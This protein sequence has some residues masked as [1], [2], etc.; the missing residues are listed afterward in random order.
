MV[1]KVPQEA[2]TELLNIVAAHPNG[3]TAADIEKALIEQVPRRTLQYRLQQLVSS[4]QLKST[5]DR[6][7]VKYL[8]ISKDTPDA[9]AITSGDDY[10][11]VI[12]LSAEGKSFVRMSRSP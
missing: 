5:G 9:T 10:A 6:R 7:W 12:R 1:K 8:P 4:G 2:L 3:I 11:D